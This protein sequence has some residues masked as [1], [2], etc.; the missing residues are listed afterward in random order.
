MPKKVPILPDN[1][2]SY[3]HFEEE[4]VVLHQIS[5]SNIVRVIPASEIPPIRF[6]Q[7]TGLIKIDYQR[8]TNGS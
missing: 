3:L 7:D 2:W 4:Y 8:R 6:D 5:N 1:P